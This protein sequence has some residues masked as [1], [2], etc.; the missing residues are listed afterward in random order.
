M[1]PDLLRAMQTPSLA[2]LLGRS[3]PA[4]RTMHDAFARALPHESWLA[5]AIGLPL[6]PVASSS[7]PIALQKMRQ[8]GM[9]PEPGV[10]FLLNPVHIHIARDHLVLTDSRRLDLSDS[11]ARS[12]FALAEPIFAE[13]G[14]PLV[15]GDAG[16]WFL[17]ADNWHDLQTS[18][19]DATCGHNVDIWMPKGAAERDWRKVQNEVQ[20]QWHASDVNRGRQMIGKNPV[21][22]L[23]LWAGTSAALL[24]Q[25]S[26]YTDS[27][28][29]SGWM[30]DFGKLANRHDHAATAEEVIAARCES[31]LL[32]LDSLLEPALGEDMSEWLDRINALEQSWFGPILQAMQTG[33]LDQCRLILTNG[34][35]LNE[36]PVTR[37]SLR[38]FWKKPSLQGLL[39]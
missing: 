23:W 33:A 32:L 4:L 26:R 18:T 38:R 2:M 10:W 22:S 24:P 1:G 30:A 19:P 27:F 37:H 21:N 29:L 25:Q 11:E 39:E 16:T 20:M 6:D 12:L 9:S 13:F 17:Q 34:T 3:Q 14:K 36:V 15:Y 28:N 35:V 5:G 31:G 8:F 7:P